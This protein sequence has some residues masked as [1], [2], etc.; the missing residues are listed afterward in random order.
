MW[1]RIVYAFC[2]EIN[3]RQYTLGI[4]YKI[5]SFVTCRSEIVQTVSGCQT[6]YL[7]YRQIFT[8]FSCDQSNA[9]SQNERKIL[10]Q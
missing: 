7:N 1:A 6:N 2:Y 5:S 10:K 9:K 4:K 3:K 8:E